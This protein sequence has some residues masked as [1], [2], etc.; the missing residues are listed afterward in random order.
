MSVLGDESEAVRFLAGIEASTMSAN[1]A[2]QVIEKIDPILLYFVVRYLRDKY[3]AGNPASQPVIEKLVELT[4]TY[5]E[6]VKHMKEAEQDPMRE[7]FDDTY[8][9]R[10]FFSTPEE[11]VHL[12]VDKLES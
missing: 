5:P 8:N 6:L 7:W 2:Y 4:S 11:F 12:I 1:D 3:P 10:D 9:M